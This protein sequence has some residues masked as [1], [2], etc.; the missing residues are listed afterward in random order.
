MFNRSGLQSRDPLSQPRGLGQA[1]AP[2]TTP[3]AS[4]HRLQAHDIL[5][6][7]PDFPSPI[8]RDPMLTPSSAH[9]RTSPVTTTASQRSGDE[10]RTNA[11]AMS[12]NDPRS[13]SPDCLSPNYMNAVAESPLKRPDPAT[14]PRLKP[15]GA[16]AGTAGASKQALLSQQHASNAKKRTSHGIDGATTLQEMWARTPKQSKV[17]P[18]CARGTQPAAGAQPTPVIDMTMC[19]DSESDAEII[20]EN[21]PERAGPS[22]PRC[23]LLQNTHSRTYAQQNSSRL[24]P[25][26]GSPAL[27]PAMRVAGIVGAA[28]GPAGGSGEPEAGRPQRALHHSATGSGDASQRR[29]RHLSGASPSERALRGN[30]AAS[31]DRPGEGGRSGGCVNSQ[32]GREDAGAAECGEHAAGGVE[33]AQGGE[34]RS[35]G[36]HGRDLP[37][38]AGAPCHHARAP[39]R[40]RSPGAQEASALGG[41]A[42]AQ[43][44]PSPWDSSHERQGPDVG[45]AEG[46]CQQGQGE[47]DVAAT[48]QGGGPGTVPLQVALSPGGE[49]GGAGALTVDPPANLREGELLC[50]NLTQGPFDT[51]R[52]GECP[53]HTTDLRLAHV[54]RVLSAEKQW[55]LDVF[56][57]EVTV[58][59]K[60]AANE[61][62]QKKQKKKQAK[63]TENMQ[64]MKKEKKDEDEDQV[65]PDMVVEKWMR[66]GKYEHEVQPCSLCC[67]AEHRNTLAS[68]LPLSFPSH[69]LNW[70]FFFAG[71]W[72]QMIHP[73]EVAARPQLPSHTLLTDHSIG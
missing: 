56:W 36:V 1:S 7:K 38:A 66:E 23:N 25:L 70:L 17:A 44:S 5:V 9:E 18:N 65:K 64:N 14:R 46:S 53:G 47:P 19:S 54:S 63:K 57:R 60:D 20:G 24:A 21:M 35:R 69:A 59:N 22:G 13:K 52:W 41:D 3:P 42:S 10:P 62:K 71:I 2:S 27:K 73:P 15:A 34:A 72:H 51:G 55:R 31:R 39:R 16:G 61:D 26:G 8:P 58:L 28:R 40:G 45:A 32:G 68:R 12:P 30:G 29:T 67:A 50:E 4:Q 37:F 43:G 33:P 6:K 49:A 48:G 11:V